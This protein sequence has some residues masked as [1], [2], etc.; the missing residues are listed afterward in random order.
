MNKVNKVNEV[1]IFTF[2]V[3]IP[4]LLVQRRFLR[5]QPRGQL[6]LGEVPVGEPGD[7][8]PASVIPKDG[9][10]M[11]SCTSSFFDG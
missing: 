7:A 3:L 4:P 9:D 2:S 5:R 10:D 8:R 1:D 6:E 11:D